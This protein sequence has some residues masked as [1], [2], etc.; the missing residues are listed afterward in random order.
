MEHLKILLV[1][2][3]KKVREP[4]K[5]Y[6]SEWGMKTLEFNK[7]SEI[8]T[9]KALNPHLIFMEKK[10]YGNCDFLSE[11]AS[12][13]FENA[14]KPG[15]VIVLDPADKIPLM[16]EVGEN[17]I[18]Q[19]PYSRATLFDTVR[20]ALCHSHMESSLGTLLVKL[21]MIYDILL[22]SI[23]HSELW[24]NKSSTSEPYEVITAKNEQILDHKEQI[25]PK[26]K[27]LILSLLKD[28][29][30]HEESGRYEEQLHLLDQY[31]TE[32]A[33]DHEDYDP[34]PVSDL[35]KTHPLSRKELKI[36]SLITRGMT[37]EEIAERLYI[38]PETVKSHRR[39]IRKKLSLVGNKVSLADFI[40]H[41][42]GNDHNVSV[43]YDT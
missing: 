23:N 42:N 19:I 22:K 41:L 21:D 11:K 7:P 29:R 9:I 30:N 2:E 25:I 5:K 26:S 16:D 32:L 24:L 15:I 36:F 43:E 13:P 34:A 12:H 18:L 20:Q 1:S 40:N 27:A 4:L 35:L 14:T 10:Y 28:A 3:E 8:S 37:T 33:Q 39:S 6:F 38:S 17:S 31:I